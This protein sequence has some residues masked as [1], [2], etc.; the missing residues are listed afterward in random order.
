MLS[1]IRGAEGGGVL[2]FRWSTFTD[3]STALQPPGVGAGNGGESKGAAAAVRGRDCAARLRR[4][5][6]AAVQGLASASGVAEEQHQQA[7]SA[8]EAR[9]L[10]EVEACSDACVQGNR[11]VDLELEVA[12]AAATPQLL[13]AALAG[14]QARC[15]HVLQA[16]E[17]VAG[18][19]QQELVRRD[20]AYVELLRQQAEETDELVGA[21]AQDSAAQQLAHAQQL[22]DVEAAYLQERAELL[23]ATKAELDAL[24][25]NRS[26]ME[27]SFMRQYLDTCTSFEN[28]LEE[29]RKAG[30]VDYIS[31]KQR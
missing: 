27:Q 2:K 24:L 11:A 4:E 1:W 26:S 14:M 19:I 29:L 21:M 7:C 10:V 31:L 13:L 6:V 18:S 3:M 15:Q 9:L 20:E 17:A 28:Q 5:G 8:Q 30:A 23:A 22:E 16:K 12:A 25:E